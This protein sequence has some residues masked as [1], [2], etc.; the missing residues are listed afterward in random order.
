[1]KSEIVRRRSNQDLSCCP[2]LTGDGAAL[3][4][5][6]IRAAAGPGE[7]GPGLV[8]RPGRHGHRLHRRQDLGLQQAQREDGLNAVGFVGFVRARQG[9]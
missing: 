7:D 2:E 1:M 5:V 6:V 9:S 8:H 4:Q 3:A